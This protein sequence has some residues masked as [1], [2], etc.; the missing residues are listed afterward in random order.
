MNIV[1]GATEQTTTV[2]IEPTKQANSLATLLT[3][4]EL[5]WRAQMMGDRPWLRISSVGLLLSIGQLQLLKEKQS[6]CQL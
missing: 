1:A 4:F 2:T 6:R 5:K 3:E